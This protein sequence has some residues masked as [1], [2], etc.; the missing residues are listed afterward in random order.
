MLCTIP[1]G[2]IEGWRCRK[3]I[4]EARD[5][6][7]RFAENL[8]VRDGKRGISGLHPQERID[9]LGSHQEPTKTL[10]LSLYTYTYIYML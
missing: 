10:P 6:G 8:E 3:A 5:Q 2:L 1:L 9:L 4:V 7:A